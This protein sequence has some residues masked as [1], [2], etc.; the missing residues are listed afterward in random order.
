MPAPDHCFNGSAAVISQL[1][2]KRF[3]VRYLWK[4]ASFFSWLV[5]VLILATLVYCGLIIVDMQQNRNAL[6]GF[7]ILPPVF[8]IIVVVVLADMLTRKKGPAKRS[9]LLLLQVL[10]AL[11]FLW[12]GWHQYFYKTTLYL[13]ADVQWIL[14]VQTNQPQ[15]AVHRSFFMPRT[16][17]DVPADGVV[18]TDRF[19]RSHEW[20]GLRVINTHG[21][22]EPYVIEYTVGTYSPPLQ[23]QGRHYYSFVLLLEKQ[24]NHMAPLTDTVLQRLYRNACVRLQ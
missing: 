21:K 6:I 20:R 2:M 14:F 11:P 3:L 8:L 1:F 23:C 10:L 15:P 22:K 16:T 19:F 24:P 12:L 18:L 4:E 5:V 13:Q 17:V 9:R 7:F